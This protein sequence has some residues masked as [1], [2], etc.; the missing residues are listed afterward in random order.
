MLALTRPRWETLAI[1]EVVE[2]S[3]A[4]TRCIRSVC[5]AANGV[6]TTAN[7]FPLP[8]LQKMITWDGKGIDGW[9]CHLQLQSE[10]SSAGTKTKLY[11]TGGYSCTVRHLFRLAPL[12]RL[13]I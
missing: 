2:E 3:R 4:P 12:V 1:A 10:G 8:L 7:P 5:Q 13:I 9:G 6:S 11:V